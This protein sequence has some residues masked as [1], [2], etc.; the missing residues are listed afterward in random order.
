MEERCSGHTVCPPPA[1]W[2]KLPE[3]GGR[4]PMSTGEAA[5]V[6]TSSRLTCTTLEGG[7]RRRGPGQSRGGSASCSAP[8]TLRQRMISEPLAYLHLCWASG[9][10]MRQAGP[11]LVEAPTG[12]IMGV[13]ARRPRLG[14]LEGCGGS[15]QWAHSPH[16]P[17]QGALPARAGLGP[18]QVPVAP[19]RRD[20]LDPL[21]TKSPRWGDGAQSPGPTLGTGTVSKAPLPLANPQGASAPGVRHGAHRRV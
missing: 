20:H 13:G 6:P 10:M 12:L 7:L 1:R 21:V 18:G 4:L 14:D 17:G 2:L 9:L 16:S 11:G 19:I 15:A 3:T 8:S 5:S